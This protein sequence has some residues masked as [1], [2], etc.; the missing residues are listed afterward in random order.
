[1]AQELSSGLRG[2]L[3]RWGGAAGGREASEGGDVRMHVAVLSEQHRKEG[4]G[5]PNTTEQAH[6]CS[7]FPPCLARSHCCNGT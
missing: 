2:E 4:Q 7:S 1:M 3:E 5:L 6:L